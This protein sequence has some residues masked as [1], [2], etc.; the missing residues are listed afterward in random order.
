MRFISFSG[1]DGS[2]K[3]TQLQ[4]LKTKLEQ[5]GKKVAYFHA[6]EF[7]LA[8]KIARLFHNQKTFQPGH[9]KATT[10]A[11]W[12]MVVLRE[13]FLFIDML[14][15]YYLLRRLQKDGYQYL[16]ADRS[17]YDSLVNLSY[18][19]SSAIVKFGMY[20]LE[21]LLP[22]ADIAFYFD[23]APEA[24]MAREHAPEQGIEYL[25]A[26]HALFQKKLSDWKLISIDANKEK[27]IIF[28]EIIQIIKP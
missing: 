13:K 3:S 27:E 16:L 26:K 22:R 17:F 2:G 5:T 28:Q 24:I 25:R 21:P 11:S 9:E 4:L 19:S 6:V 8:N 23:I 10:N 20:F 7:S 15:F 1:V 14:R 12:L 18:L